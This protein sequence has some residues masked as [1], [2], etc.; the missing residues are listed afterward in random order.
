MIGIG[1]VSRSGKTDLSKFLSEKFQELGYTVVTLHQDE[2]VFHEKEIPKIKD[3]TDWEIPDSINFSQYISAIKEAQQNGN[4]VVIVEGFLNFYKNEVT[5]L[6]DKK[7]FLE[8]SR[9]TFERRRR[10]DTRWS[11]EPDW[12]IDYIWETYEKYG[13]TILQSDSDFLK[14]SGENTSSYPAVWDYVASDLEIKM[15]QLKQND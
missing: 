2:F 11:R 4:E 1:G 10:N 3:R 8:I 5:E 12:Y 6:F 14:I 9:H 13:N 15:N 7:I